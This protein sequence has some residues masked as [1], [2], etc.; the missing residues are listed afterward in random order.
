MPHRLLTEDF[1]ETPFWWEAAPRPEI[2]DARPP[3]D[4]DVV[5]VG[6]GNV[7]LS[8]ALTLSRGGCKVVVLDAEE[9]GHGGSS[10]NAGYI[11]RTLWFK[12]PALKQKLGLE[13]A[14]TLTEAGARAHDFVADLIERE[15]I[16]CHFIDNGRFI[17]AL[18]ASSYKKLEKDL[19]SMRRD[20][21]EVDSWMVPRERQREELG[22]DLYHGGQVLCGTGQLHPGLYHLGL[23]DRVRS[24][25]AITVGYCPATDIRRDG[26]RHLVT[27]PK[28]TIRARDVVVATNGYTPKATPWMRRRVVPVSAYMIATEPLPADTMKRLFPSFRTMIDIRRN[29]FWARPSHDGERL[30][31]GAQ[32]GMQAA[33]LEAKALSLHAALTQVFPELAET[34]ISHCWTGQ[35]AFTFDMLPH[36]GEHDGVHYAMGFCAAGVPMGSYMG[37]K[38]A[39]RILG[40]PDART[41]FD[42]LTFPTK[43]FY[44]G[45]PWF[46]PL[47]VGY[48]N[49]MDR[50]LW[51]S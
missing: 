26:D 8:A 15:Q 48:F 3:D 4:A 24:Q 19:D 30:L 47:I 39:Q 9:L 12:Y 5:V 7:G 40:D 1:K 2:D 20:G 25:G 43:P 16:A 32:T 22:S 42:G 29:P 27:T 31:F 51:K 23:L 28:G 37:H 33:S 10:R 38:T 36:T 41:P 21:V 17:P 45:H 46:L 6:S 35:V 11:G 14:K 50:K 49:H 44:T 34:R 13:A 18:S